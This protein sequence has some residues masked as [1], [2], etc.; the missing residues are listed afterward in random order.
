MRQCRVV[1]GCLVKSSFI[2]N[3]CY[4]ALEIIPSG[5]TYFKSVILLLHRANSQRTTGHKREKYE[6]CG[7]QQ[8]RRQTPEPWYNSIIKLSYEPECFAEP[9]MNILICTYFDRKLVTIF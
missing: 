1:K 2:R 6:Y 4:H 7:R 9:E 8:Q 3:E 5:K